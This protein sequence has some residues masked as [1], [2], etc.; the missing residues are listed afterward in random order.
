MYRKILLQL[1]VAIN[2][3][4]VPAV[5]ATDTSKAKVVVF[6]I[7]EEIAPSATRL[8]SKALQMARKTHADLI[9]INM[10][11]Y[12]GL[13]DDADS[14]RYAILNSKIPVVVYINPN[15]ASAGALISI[16]CKHI[17]MSKGASIGAAT[18]VT[19]EGAAAPDKYQSYMRS[20]MRST[21]EA[22]GKTVNSVGDTIWKRNPTIAEAMVDQDIE[23]PGV[24]AKGKVITFTP[25]EAMQYGFCEGI[26]G[27]IDEVIQA[28]GISHYSIIKV[29]KSTIDIIFGFLKNPA[30][31][32]V[33][34]LLIIGGIYYELRTP[35]IGFPIV[36]S[37]ISALL[38][39]A[40]NYIDGLAEN[41]E[42]LLFIAG[43]ILLLI[44]LFAIPGFGI[45]GILGIVAI[46]SS[47]VLSLVPNDGFDFTI[48]SPAQIGNAFL[49]VSV[50]IAIL[51][52][53]FIYSGVSLHNS[54]ILKMVSLE[55]DL[56]QS[57][58]ESIIE[59]DSI[60]AG[61]IGIAF[62]DIK[63]QGKAIMQDKIVPAH[64]IYGFISKGAEV[65]FIRNEGNSW[66]VESRLSEN[67]DS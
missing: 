14:I 22:H 16:A 2:L 50:A 4:Y 27:S 45:I 60:K 40:P 61:D 9:V 18:V 65:K 62:T 63:P 54:P 17:Y 1:I 31:S 32:G 25:E 38:Y 55:S 35:G 6:D 41:W 36:V 7:K 56:A 29:E 39:F 47:L 48:Q 66:L 13:V 42:I 28:E 52:S 67:I 46:L 44:E 51:I 12:G 24:S 33:L 26:K 15:A 19:Q 58:Q 37:A 8:V 10:D 20:I 3:L 23:V 11:T 30:V 59:E 5:N 34:V 21:A 64:S 43:V 57:K 49:I 53:I